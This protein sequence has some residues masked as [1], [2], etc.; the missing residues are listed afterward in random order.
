MNVPQK[1][2]ITCHV[3]DT[4]VGKPAANVPVT[5]YKSVGGE[6]SSMNRRMTNEDGRCNNLVEVE[7]FTAGRYKVHFLTSQYFESINTKSMYPFVEIVF[8]FDDSSDHYH[9]PLLLSPFGYSTYRGS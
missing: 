3:L 4:S 8:D 5:L 9:I 6:W 7:N 2:P 1:S